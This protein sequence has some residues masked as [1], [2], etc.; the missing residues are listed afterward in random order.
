MSRVTNSAGIAVYPAS[1]RAPEDD[2]VRV[3]VWEW[4]VRLTHWVIVIAIVL[5]SATGLYIAHPF[6]ISGGPAGANFLMGTVRV[7]HLYAGIAFAIAVLARFY[8]F[9]AGNPYARW[10]KYVPARSRRRRGIAPTI[11]FYLFAQRKPPGFVGHNPVAGL[12]YTLVFG[13]YVTALASGLALYLANAPVHS[14]FR[15]FRFLIPL[16]GGFQTARW[17]HHVA[18]WLLLGFAVHHVYSGLLMSQIEQNATMESIFSG[19][20]FVPRRD[21]RASGYDYLGVNETDD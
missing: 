8:W 17:I 20:K 2:I 13:L 12:A 4:P 14:P 5:L 10:D 18:M 11:R 7:V 16:L 15:I 3:Y 6:A 9:F 19:Y 21:L 1:P